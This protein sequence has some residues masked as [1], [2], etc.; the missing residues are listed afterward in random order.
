MIGF[1]SGTARSEQVTPLSV[2]YL[3]DASTVILTDA[4]GNNLLADTVVVVTPVY[5][6]PLIL[7]QHA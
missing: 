6:V 5:A 4:S 2:V 7:R 1:L 3:L